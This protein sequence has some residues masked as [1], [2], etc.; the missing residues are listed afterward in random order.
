MQRAQ[1]VIESLVLRSPLDGVVSLKENRDAAGGVMFFGMILPDYREGDQVWPGRPVADVIESGRMEI[2]ARIDEHDRGNLVEGQRATVHVD[3]LPGEVFTARVG[4]LSGLASRPTFFDAASVSRQFDVTFSFDDPDPRLRAGGSAR[5]VVEGTEIADAIHVPRQAVFARAGKNHVFVRAGDRFEE[6][7]VTVTQRTE[8]RVVVEGL[9]EG[10][11]IALVDPTT[12]PP[13]TPRRPGR[14]RCRRPGARDDARDGRLGL[15]ARSP[16]GAREPP[17]AQAALAAHHDGHDLRRG[18]RRRDA[19]DRRGRAAGGDGLHRAARRAQ[20]HRRGAGGPGPA[21][22]PEDPEALGGPQ[23]PG[24]P[25]HRANVDGITAST[26][27]KR[28]TPTKLLPR[29]QGDAPVVY[30]VSPDYTTIANLHVVSGRFFDE[31]ETEAAAPVAVLGEAAAAT[32]FGTA[33]PVGEYVKVNEQWFQVIGV[34]G[35]QL[36]A[37]TDIAGIPAQD[38]NNLIYVP[39]YAAIFRL[40]DGQSAPA[41]RDRRHL[42]ADAVVERGARLGGAPAG[43][44]ERLAP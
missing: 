40:E 7:E 42:S 32:L 23:F 2:R 33:D 28:F 39:L 12:R 30:G 10:D 9:S 1:Q 35:P 22:A 36:T 6:R 5:L 19:V 15:A 34:A 41:R 20:P 16:H 11:E 3:A 24:L 8:S 17:R 25:R 31:R 14:L 18:G 21:D 27:R 37:Q 43:A 44:A 26:A 29:P 38:R 13:E 4:S